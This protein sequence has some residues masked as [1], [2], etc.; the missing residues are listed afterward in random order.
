MTEYT[1]FKRQPALSKKETIR[2]SLLES[3]KAMRRSFYELLM[4]WKKA[5]DK[6]DERLDRKRKVLDH[7]YKI[8]EE[9]FDE[10]RERAVKNFK[11]KIDYS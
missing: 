7:R 5:L 3:S 1:Y 10:H 4:S 11:K 2:K 9:L 6:E 8:W